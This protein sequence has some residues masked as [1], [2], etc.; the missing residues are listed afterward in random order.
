[1]LEAETQTDLHPIPSN[2]VPN[3][4]HNIWEWKR[5]ALYLVNYFFHIIEV[6]LNRIF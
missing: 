1:M 5:Q 6:V 3:Y 4:A 2:I